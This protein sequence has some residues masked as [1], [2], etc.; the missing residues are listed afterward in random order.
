MFA[1]YKSQH[2]IV[3]GNTDHSPLAQLTTSDGSLSGTSDFVQSAQIE[4]ATNPST[5]ANSQPTPPVV[6]HDASTETSDSVHS[7]QLESATN[8]SITANSQPSLPVVA[9][10]ASTETSDSD[11]GLNPPS[12]KVHLVYYKK[13]YA[14]SCQIYEEIIKQILNNKTR[15]VNLMNT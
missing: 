15:C 1:K 3:H 14:D 2:G 11:Q 5:T 4:S 10:D 7:A 12:D 13:Q 9:Q 8:P 6:T